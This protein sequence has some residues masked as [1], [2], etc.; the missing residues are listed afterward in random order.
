MYPSK[1]P[2]IC[3]MSAVL[4][5]AVSFIVL[6][7]GAK[8]ADQSIVESISAAQCEGMKTHHVLNPSTPVG[9][10]RL[11]LVKFSYFGFD[12]KIHDDGEIVVMDAVA[13]HVRNIFTILKNMQ[14][15]IAKAKLLNAYDGN[16]FASMA[17]NNTSAFNDR[18]MTGGGALSLHAYGLAI[19]L[20][21]IQNPFATRSGVSLMFNP[22]SGI[23]YANRLNDRPGKISRLGLAEAAVEVFANDGFMIWG[24]YWDDPIDYQHFQV[25]RRLAGILSRLSPDE[26]K[27]KFESYVVRYRACRRTKDRSNCIVADDIN[28]DHIGD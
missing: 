20:N 28:N 6:P 10:D 26:A 27:A 5:P 24:G 11:K 2:T 21:P 12:S 14:F 8:T 22:P 1:L 7:S 9:C 23:Y 25:S 17:D 18:P 13:E 19:D 15:P 16:D 3:L 4:F